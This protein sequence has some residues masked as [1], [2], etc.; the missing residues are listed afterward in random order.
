VNTKILL[1]VITLFLLS[2]SDPEYRLITNIPVQASFI[3]SD[4]LG[5]CY[6]VHS[7]VLEEYNSNGKLLKSYSNK[8]LG[9]ITQVDVSDPLKP[10]LFY[11]DFQKIVW[12]DNTLSST[13]TTVNFEERGLNDVLL[14]ASSHQDGIWVFTGQN[15][16]LVRLDAQIEVTTRTGNLRQLLGMDSIAPNW[17]VEYNN[18]LYLNSPA[19]GILVFDVYGTYSRTIP[20]K[21][22]QSFQVQDD[23]VLWQKDGKLH[24]Y[25][26]K[27][28][29]EQELPLPHAAALSVRAEKER[30]FVRTEKSVDI[31]NAH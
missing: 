28:L 22:L 8:T 23:A 24:S 9:N 26:I 13:A 10:L 15:S 27:T 3:T 21:Q 6:I 1:S 16:E 25:N 14:V 12:L 18:K 30:I 2:F 5:N 19:D 7:D 31:Y 29:E 4:N 17:L 11:R 20:V